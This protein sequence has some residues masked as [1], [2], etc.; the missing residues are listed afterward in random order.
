MFDEVYRY[1]KGFVM[2]V[3]KRLVSLDEQRK[4]QAWLENLYAALYEAYFSASELLKKW[5]DKMREPV[6]SE[7]NEL[8]RWKLSLFETMIGRPSLLFQSFLVPIKEQLVKKSSEI[9]RSKSEKPEFV[10]KALDVVAAF[11]Q[12]QINELLSKVDKPQSNFFK[13]ALIF[14]AGI[15]SKDPIMSIFSRDDKG[16]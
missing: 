8:A 3:A 7:A 9:L 5:E 11:D 1:E 14:V 13:N 16:E 6:P 15:M 4:K 10:S 2:E 12:P